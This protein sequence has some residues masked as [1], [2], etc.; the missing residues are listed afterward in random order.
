MAKHISSYVAKPVGIAP[1]VMQFVLRHNTTCSMT[2]VLSRSYIKAIALES[3]AS[4]SSIQFG[5]IIGHT[6]YAVKERMSSNS[7]PINLHVHPCIWLATYALQIAAKY[8]LDQSCRLRFIV[9]LPKYVKFSLSVVSKSHSTLTSSP[10]NTVTWG[11]NLSNN[12][13][14][15]S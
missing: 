1:C 13:V 14:T 9:K 3:K 7:L 8:T 12:T 15:W 2:H 5:L 6:H 4:Q 11:W 10:G